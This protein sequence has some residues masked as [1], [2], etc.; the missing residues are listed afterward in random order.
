MF[1]YDP[2][3][4]EHLQDYFNIPV[5]RNHLENLGLIEADGTIVDKRKFQRQQIFLD[6]HLHE[7]SHNTPVKK[8]IGERKQRKKLR[9]V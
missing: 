2:L 9:K 7:E 4:D 5:V 1:Q 6:K 3:T 8:N